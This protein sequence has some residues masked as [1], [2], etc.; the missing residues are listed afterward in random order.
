MWAPA[1]TESLLKITMWKSGANAALK[2][3]SNIHI[4]NLLNCVLPDWTSPFKMK[5]KH[6]SKNKIFVY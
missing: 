1:M 4:K 5:K 3:G 6:M 2:Q